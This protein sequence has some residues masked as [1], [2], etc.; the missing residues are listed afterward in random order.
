M[1]VCMLGSDHVIV[2]KL[3]LENTNTDE[4]AP[5]HIIHFRVL[6]PDNPQRIDSRITTS[7]LVIE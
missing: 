7:A 4:G 1:R 3:R 6:N 5:R 2:S